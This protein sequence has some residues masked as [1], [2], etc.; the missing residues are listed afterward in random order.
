MPGYDLELTTEVFD[1][2]PLH[3]REFIEH[4]GYLDFHLNRWL[5]HFDH[6][7]FINHNDDPNI[8]PNYESDPHG[9][10]VA[11]RDIAVGEEITTDY[12]LFEKK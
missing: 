6:G 10:D 12:R 4:Y 2:L 7:R 5:L 3:V 9:V 8:R 11:V 1:A